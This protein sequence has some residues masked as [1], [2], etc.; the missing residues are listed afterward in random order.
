MRKGIFDWIVAVSTWLA[1]AAMPDMARASTAAQLTSGVLHACARTPEGAAYCWGGGTSGQLGDGTSTNRT[2]PTPVSGLSSGVNSVVAGYQ[3][4]CALMTGG[5]VRCWGRND[6]AQLGDG[7]ITNRSL[8]VAVQ[9]LTNVISIGAGTSH[10]CA[11]TASGGVKCWGNNNQGA[12]GDGTTATV[13]TTP[14]DAVG[15]TGAIAV[16]LGLSHTCALL[17][18]G[19]VQCWG[20]NAYGQL[21]NGTFTGSIT[22]VDVV[23]I[24]DAVA[25]VTGQYHTCVKTASGAMKCW[26]RNDFGQLG[27]GGGA[28]VASPITVSGLATGVSDVLAPSGGGSTCA[29]LASGVTKCWGYNGSGQLGTG[30]RLNRSLPADVT[31]LAGSVLTMTMGGSAACA[32]VFNGVQCWGGNNV[33]Q[34]GAGNTVNVLFPQYV[35]GF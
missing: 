5:S 21:G 3:H 14:V 22:R 12:L 25:L 7:S 15:V 6:L 8:P 1:L 29:I 35:V 30:D 28:N 4:T 17:A 9:G 19:R 26:G 13:R 34:H 10:T 11:V 23:G 2:T 33:G 16:S 24:T 27:N 20:L 31:G 32:R 18:N